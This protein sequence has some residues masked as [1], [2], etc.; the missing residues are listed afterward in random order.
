FQMN[1]ENVRIGLTQDV[2][3]GSVMLSM[4]LGSVF[5]K[6]KFIEEIE[7]DSVTV[8]EEVLSRLPKWQ[9]AAAADPRLQIAR[10]RLNDLKLES[11]ALQLPALNVDLLLIADGAIGR[12]SVSTADGKLRV[13]LTPRGSEVDIAVAA[14]QGWVPAIGPAIQFTDLTAK[15]VASGTEIRVDE[16]NALFYGGAAKG[17]ARIQWG[18]P[19]TLEGDVG[20]ERAGLQELMSVFTKDAKSSGQLEATLRYAMSSPTLA[21]LFNTPRVDG[22]FTARKG[23]LDGV[24]LVRALQVGGRDNVQGGAT[25]FEEISGTVSVANNRYQYRN[26]RLSA[27]LLSATGGAEIAP[28]KDVSGRVAVEL[29]SQAAQMRGNFNVTGNLKAIVLRPN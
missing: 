2:K 21:T 4:G 15:A 6:N 9:E 7:A 3:A 11:R 29:R 22:S 10:L 14:D 12:A 18:G 24:D 16:F 20:I 25:R 26:L 27:G 17:S 23:D 5:G 19:W 8:A 13:E 1:L 28:D